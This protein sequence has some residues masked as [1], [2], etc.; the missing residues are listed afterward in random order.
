MSL[1]TTNMIRQQFLRSVQGPDSTGHISY[2]APCG[3]EIGI[4]TATMQAGGAPE[5]QQSLSGI[6]V[7]LNDPKAIDWGALI[8]ALLPLITQSFTPKSAEDAASDKQYSYSAPDGSFCVMPASFMDRCKTV[9]G[10]ACL[11]SAVKVLTGR[12]V[13]GP[14]LTILI[15]MLPTLLPALLPILLGLCPK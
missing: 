11:S 4:T 3:L 7:K 9:E 1:Q 2:S 12:E 10:M 13:A 14:I 6:G 15:Q 8:Q 5:V